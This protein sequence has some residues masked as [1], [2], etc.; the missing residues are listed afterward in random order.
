MG[1]SLLQI[2]ETLLKA[3]RTMYKLGAIAYENM[4][5]EDSEDVDFERDIIYVYKKAVEYADDLYIGTTKLDQ[6]VERLA[7]KLVIYDYG[8]LNPIYSDSTI[9]T[10]VVPLG[11][12]LNDLSDVT[13]TNLQD[14]QTLKYNAALGQWVNVGTG[15]AVRNTQQFTATAGQTTFTTAYQ[16]DGG[17][18]DIF[19]N[20]VKLSTPSY[21]VFGNYTIILTDGCV[22]GDI[23]EIVAYENN[24]AFIDLS[25][26]YVPV[27]R[28]I[29]I[30]GVTYDLS[31]NRSWTTVSS[32]GI[33]MP[34][35]FTVS[36][37]PVTTS[38]TLTVTGAGTTA[39]Y[40]RGDGT[41]AT[42]PTLT[43]YVPYTGATTNVNL[44]EFELKAGQLTLD[45][46]P[47]GTA[48]VGTIR[49]N[50]TIGSSETTLKGGSVILKNGVDLVARVVN[51]V[52]P[53][54][55]LTKASYR[56]V[57][58]S[59]AQGQRL[60]VAYAQANNDNNSADTLGLVIETIPTNQE[61]FIITVGQIEDINTTGSL[62]GETWVDG[63][64]LYLSPTTPGAITNVKPVAPQ[65]IVVIGY[66]EYAHAINGKIYVKVMNGWELGEL[67]D[68]NTTGAIN[69]SVLKYNGTI[70]VPSSDTGITSLNGLTSLSQTFATGT[71]GTDFNISSVSS[72]HTFNIPDASASARGLITTGAQTI[73]GAKTF[74]SAVT[75]TNF[76]L[77]GG[78]GNTGLYYGHT[79][80]VVLAN[81]VVGGGIDFETNGG[82]INMVLDASANLSVV[83]SVTA[84]SLIKSGGTSSQFLKADGS[85]DS[86]IYYLAS[87]PSGYT[88]NVGTVTSVA[89]TAGTG[90][91]ISGSPITTSGTLTITN[92]A[93]DQV[94][95]LT[96]STGISVSGTYPNFTIT[97]TSPSSGGTVTSVGL[98]SAT[99]GVTIGSSPITTSGTITLAIATATTSQNGL[100]SSADWTTFNNKQ[101]TIT[102]PVTGTGTTNYLPKWTSASAIGNSVI[103]EASGSIGVGTTALTSG[104]PL[105]INAPTGSN[106]NL[107]IQQNGTDKWYLRNISGTDDFSFYSVVNS[108]ERMR[109][110]SGGNLLVGT[111]FDNG[112]KFQVS[113]AAT[114][115]S[116]V[117]ATSF[118]KSGGTSSQYL[119]ADGSVTTGSSLTITN[120]QTASYTLVLAD[121]DKLVEMNVATANN[122]TVPLNSS[123]AFPV[124][125][126][127][128][129][130]QYGAGQTTVV[131]TGGVTVRSAGGAL[132]LAV[133]YS[134]A[135]LVKIATNEWYLFGDI[136]V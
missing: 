52:T 104:I 3:D 28:T 50:D 42:F 121:A 11:A 100:L 131:A 37:S 135:T 30:N 43:G 117:T 112:S 16:F 129:L 74:S 14:Q 46:S 122:L 118:I 15:N 17:L 47:T 73:T 5:S 132:K 29:T 34:S 98:S 62:Q 51:K 81:Y 4:F 83:G 123:I 65:H 7:N 77:S 31:A 97:N 90:I 125:T 9:V 85:V 26:Y 13:I 80:K 64:V 91:T 133:Q 18:V 68:V 86:S 66:V 6:V 92:S 103:Y 10:Q 115:S 63:D 36:N 57:R 89:A 12:A 95:A 130:A 67:H 69:G 55:T 56:A 41:L 128:D 109:I 94:V 105:T 78:T 110:T 38:G 96:A 39:Q 61:G 49:W 79:N 27:G 102:N 70:W 116:S 32:V 53:N 127:I 113:G 119:M 99:S 71:S 87:N 126:K 1:Y 8:Q 24:I 44:G 72:A 93:P 84:A 59:G 124:G 35:A 101:N 107:A 60:A 40:I 19:V 58:I 25:A 23:V 45:T 20:G 21:T 22:S 76:I 136:T 111:T 108:A 48:A 120:R 82:A 2:S 33:S 75:S 106:T 134:G 114:F 54:A 88:T